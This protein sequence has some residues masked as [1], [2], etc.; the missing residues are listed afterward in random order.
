M[1]F[2]IGKI[3]GIVGAGA[4]IASGIGAFAAPAAL[5]AAGGGGF[6]S[7]L[8]TVGSVLGT[9]GKL[10]GA[11]GGVAGAFAQ[12]ASTY[13]GAQSTAFAAKQ[14]AANYLDAAENFTFQSSTSKLNAT[15]T[16][17][18]RIYEEQRAYAEL[19]R[20]L[21]SDNKVRQTARVGYAASG[22]KISGSAI[23]VIADMATEQALNRAL[24]KYESDQRVR[25]FQFQEYASTKEAENYEKASVR[26]K[27]NAASVLEEGL[28]ASKGQKGLAF[29]QG[30]D[31]IPKAIQGVSSLMD[32]FKG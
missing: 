25:G 3:L 15:I 6:L 17:A 5:G 21:R 8:G 29:T 2:S 27:E 9:V 4:A 1:G 14:A 18:N 20:M 19:D 26:A 12:P 28:K 7:S 16:K 23:D 32:F 13:M 24:F 10:A 11:V 30:L 31:A 22:V